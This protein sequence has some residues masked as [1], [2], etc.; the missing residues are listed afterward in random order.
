MSGSPL[1]GALDV[2]GGPTPTML[3]AGNSPVLNAGDPGYVGTPPKDQRGLPRKF[4]SAID[5]GAVER[6]SPEDI[7][8]RNGFG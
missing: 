1:L 5:I 8:F 4:G 7:I 6:Q 3:P 2:Y